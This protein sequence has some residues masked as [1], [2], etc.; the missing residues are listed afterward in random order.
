M[1][2]Q[3]KTQSHM[4]TETKEITLYNV[5]DLKENPIVLQNVLD[6]QMDINVDTYIWYED[7]IYTHIQKLKAVGFNDVE[8]AFRGF[9]SQGDG[10]SFICESIDF[11]KWLSENST[12][13]NKRLLF[14]LNNG[15]IEITGYIKRDRNTCYCHWNTTTLHLD[16]NIFGEREYLNISALIEQLDKDITEYMQNCS[17]EI[18]VELDD[19]YYELISEKAILE[20]LEANEYEFTADG[21]IYI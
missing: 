16:Y 1:S 7:I 17:K 4:K 8:I 13:N 15:L 12:N 10:A 6:K 2:Y 18:Y 20:T 11:K 14:L 19:A 21:N 5:S 9:S 3:I